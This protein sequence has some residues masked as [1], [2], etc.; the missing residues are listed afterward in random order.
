MTGVLQPPTDPLAAF[1]AHRS[2][3]RI[4]YARVS[5]AGQ[6]LERQLDTLKAAARPHRRPTHRHYPQKP[7]RQQIRPRSCG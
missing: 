5:T 6:N 7:E 2:E 3:I 1:P 4:G